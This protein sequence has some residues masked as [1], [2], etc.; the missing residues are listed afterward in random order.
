VLGTSK[1]PSSGLKLD[2]FED[3]SGHD[4]FVVEGSSIPLLPKFPSGKLD[5]YSSSSA[6]EEA[7]IVSIGNDIQS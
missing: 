7:T 3:G 6:D 2:H 4:A 1:G 5:P